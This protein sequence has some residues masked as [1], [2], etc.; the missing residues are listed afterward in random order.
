LNEPSYSG[1]DAVAAWAIGIC[2]AN[3]ATAIDIVP[4]V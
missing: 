3:A 4:R 2:M 1:P